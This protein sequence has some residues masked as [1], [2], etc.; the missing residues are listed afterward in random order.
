[1]MCLTWGPAGLWNTAKQWV[2]RKLGRDGP[3]TREAAKATNRQAV[4]DDFTAQ[5]NKLTD[6]TREKGDLEKKLGL[7][8]GPDGEYLPLVDQ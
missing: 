4:K 8:L 3:L 1:M 5:Q 7:D 6:L 2:L